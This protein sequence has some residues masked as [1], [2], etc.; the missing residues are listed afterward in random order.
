MM[1]WKSMAA[2]ALSAALALTALGGCSAKGDGR[3]DGRGDGKRTSG[4]RGSSGGKE[5]SLKMSI[6]SEQRPQKKEEVVDEA[7]VTESVAYIPAGSIIT[8][9]ILTGGD[10]PLRGGG[11]SRRLPLAGGRFRRGGRRG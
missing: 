2:L 6:I 3:G 5:S 10:F 7:P 9:T 4:Q 1:N 8:G 11:H